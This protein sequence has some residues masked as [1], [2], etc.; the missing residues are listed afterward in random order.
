[1][2]AASLAFTFLIILFNT[3]CGQTNEDSIFQSSFQ[4]YSYINDQVNRIEWNALAESNSSYYVVEKQTS[5]NT[6][7]TL[8]TVDVSEVNNPFKTYYFED[9]TTTSTT[10]NPYRLTLVHMDGTRVS[11]L[12]NQNIKPSK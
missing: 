11:W 7:E 4:V 6:Y 10:L 3:S 8:G 5:S 9:F 1:M 12:V 2:K